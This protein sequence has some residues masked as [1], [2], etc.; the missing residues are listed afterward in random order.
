MEGA[1]SEYNAAMHALRDLSSND[2]IDLIGQENP[3]AKVSNV[4]DAVMVLVGE[5]VGWSST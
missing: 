5:P 2:L 4:M 1:T 3:D